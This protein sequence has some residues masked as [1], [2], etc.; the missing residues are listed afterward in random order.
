MRSYIRKCAVCIV[1][2]RIASGTRFKILE[3]AALARPT[4]STRIGAEGLEFLDGAEIILADAPEAFARSVAELLENPLR[5]RAM[6]LAA[7]R[8]VE[9]DYTFPKLCRAL[10]ETL[11]LVVPAGSNIEM[12]KLARLQ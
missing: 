11:A 3:A 12:S 10:E 8:R 1:P 9:T 6:G 4:V 7:R 5:R 2:L